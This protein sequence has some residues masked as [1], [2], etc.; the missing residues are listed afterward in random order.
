MKI[1][2]KNKEIEPYESFYWDTSERFFSG[3]LGG[4]NFKMCQNNKQFSGISTL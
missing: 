4:G 1:K 2:Y 3:Q